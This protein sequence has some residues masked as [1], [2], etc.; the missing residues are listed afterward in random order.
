MLEIL[1]GLCSL[2]GVSGR[3]DAVRGF[4]LEQIRPYAQEITVDPHGSIIAL[5][6]GAERAPRRFMFSA[7]M[8]EVGFIITSVE[9]NGCLRFDTVGGIDPRVL[10]FRAVRINNIPGVICA[11]SAYML[12]AQEKAKAPGV[13]ELYIDIGAKS[14]EEASDRVRPGDVG[15]FET[16]FE[17][18]GEGRLKARA[19]DDRAGCAVLIDIMK[20]ELQY[21]AYFV[22][23]VQEEVGLRGAGCAAFT[24]EPDAALVVE[25]TTAADI[26]DVSEQGVCCRVGDGAV[27][28]FMDLRTVYDRELYDLAL[29]CA[30]SRGLKAQVKSAVAGGND[31]GAIQGVRGGVA[32][33]ALSLPCRYLHSG[34]SMIAASDLEAVRALSQG[35]F[36]EYMKQYSN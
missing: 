4:I 21:D 33:A 12:S 8:D 32:V 27:I 9:P 1:K 31:A 15:T 29:S 16:A 7:H 23:C 5:K 14:A 11:K 24:V 18:L 26:P 36:E 2:Q 3:E 30:S 35:L 34:A 25:S 19:L 22:F 17:E 20:Q 28:S 10:C 13:S 6:R